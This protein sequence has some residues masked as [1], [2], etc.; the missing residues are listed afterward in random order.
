VVRSVLI[1]KGTY[2]DAN[3]EL[4]DLKDTVNKD[5]HIERKIYMNKKVYVGWKSA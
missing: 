4:H 1:I 3:L 5:A 2:P